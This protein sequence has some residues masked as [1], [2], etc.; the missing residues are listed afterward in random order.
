MQNPN[1]DIPLKDI[2]PLLEIHEYSFYYFLVLIVIGILILLGVAYIV[3][4]WFKNKQRY[5]IR[6]EH[7]KLLNKIN[8]KD[9]KKAAYAIT[10]YGSTFKDDGSRQREMFHNLTQRLESFKYKKDVDKLDDETLGYI[11][12]YK[13][14]IDV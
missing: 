4:K 13:G 8:L 7:F 5:N 9:S 1:L 12:L 3:Y 14:M 10:L 6:K 2:K 11:E